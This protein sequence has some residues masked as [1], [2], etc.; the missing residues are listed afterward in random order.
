MEIDLHSRLLRVS[1]SGVKTE[2]KRIYL[3]LIWV[4]AVVAVRLSFVA[5]PQSASF[6]VKFRSS[7]FSYFAFGASGKSE[8]ETQ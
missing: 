3:H 8:R 1:G 4:I 6:Q 2:I 7:N 5:V